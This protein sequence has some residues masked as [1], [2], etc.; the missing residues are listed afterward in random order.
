MNEPNAGKLRSDLNYL[1][2]CY[3]QNNEFHKVGYRKPAG[4]VESLA[5][6][7]ARS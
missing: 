7:A 1:K 4:M 5:R 6:I 2:I 3:M